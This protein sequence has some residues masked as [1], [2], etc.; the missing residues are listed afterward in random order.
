MKNNYEELSLLWLQ[1]SPLKG[2]SRNIFIGFPG[3]GFVL[4]MEGEILTI[5][6]SDVLGMA[7]TACTKTELNTLLLEKR[8]DIC[9]RGRYQF[10]C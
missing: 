6:K 1:L 8:S 5:E 7:V 10:L 4:G 3:L 9:P 2:E